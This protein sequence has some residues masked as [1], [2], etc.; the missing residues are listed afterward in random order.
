MSQD[1]DFV[2]TGPSSVGFRTGPGQPLNIETGGLFEGKNVGVEGKADL[3]A[4]VSGNSV[5]DDGV[6]GTTSTVGKSG[7]FGFNTQS[8]GAAFG[9]SGSS[10]SP[11]G[12]GVN[13][14]SDPGVGV[15]GTSKANDGVVGSSSVAGKSGVFGFNT[16]SNGAAFGVSGSS[17]SPDGAGVNGF[18][19]KGYGGNFSGGRASMRL[20]PAN[21]SG[22]PTTGNHQRGEFFVDS[23][24]E[25]FYCRDS[26]TPG[27]WFRVHLTPA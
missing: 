11:D 3:G 17:G 21:T 16:Q 18:S 26:G 10:G 19:G 4:G 5:S 27:H 20:I 24:G 1:T 7:V 23:N 13:G 2:A 12:A 14:F 8:N 25:L 6:V 22:R 15:R 9:V